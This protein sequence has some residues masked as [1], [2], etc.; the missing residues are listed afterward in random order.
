VA[1]VRLAESGVCD[2]EAFYLKIW[3][4]DDMAFLGKCPWEDDLRHATDLCRRIGVPL[5]IVPLQRE[6]HQRVVAHAIDELRAG[7]TPSPDVV[8]N[9]QIKFGAFLEAVG[10]AGVVA[11]G[12]HARLVFDGDTPHLLKGVDPVKDQTYFLCLLEKGQLVRCR[13]PIGDLMKH[14]IR[15]LARARGLSTA[16]R[17]DSQGICFLGRVPYADF[18]HF[19]LGERRGKIRDIADG[20][21]LGE[22]RGYWFHTIGQRRGL[23]LAGGPW[24]VVDKDI[25]E[26]VVWVSHGEALAARRRDIVV[27]PSPNWFAGPPTLSELEVKLR[28]GPN[29]IRSQVDIESSG[30]LVATLSEPDPGVAAGQY[31]VFYDG[32]RCLGGGVIAETPLQP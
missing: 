10:D 16:D 8:C 13:F 11:T 25:T 23:G 6:Y 14:E 24:Y 26:N 15:D 31:A 1:L 7:R 12:H 21:T 30:A 22:H 5:H 19:H 3:L 17:P 4:E 28:H 27:V 29:V 18:I 2:L 20:R 9:Q 32:A